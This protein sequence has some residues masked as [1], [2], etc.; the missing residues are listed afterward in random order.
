[1]EEERENRKREGEKE[2]D[3]DFRGKWVR[4]RKQEKENFILQRV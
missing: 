2:K 4:G 3:T 1:M